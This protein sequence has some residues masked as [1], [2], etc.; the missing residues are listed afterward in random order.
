VDALTPRTVRCPECGEDIEPGE[1]A[2]KR[3]PGEWS[4]LIGLR[5]AAISIAVRC[6]IVAIAWAGLLIGMDQVLTLLGYSGSPRLRVLVIPMSI[7]AY[8]VGWLM[9]HKLDEHAGFHSW[10]ITWLSVIVLF[11]GLL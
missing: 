4:E 10:L 7:C 3:R 2:Y 11:A 8:I 1:F 5:N 9:S 6:A